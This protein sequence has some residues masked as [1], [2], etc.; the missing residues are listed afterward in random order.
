MIDILPFLTGLS[1]GLRGLALF[2]GIILILDCI[3]I[4][5]GLVED[6]P[7]RSIGNARAW[8][9]VAL[10]S[11]IGCWSVL[12]LGTSLFSAYK[13]PIQTVSIFFMWSF[14]AA[15]LVD[16]AALRTSRPAYIFVSSGLFLLTATALFL[17]RA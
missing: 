12:E 5:A 16:R 7:H 15:G 11:V 1:Q 9:L 14:I 3:K 6:P 2:A 13:T 17:G 8:G 10:G 4:H